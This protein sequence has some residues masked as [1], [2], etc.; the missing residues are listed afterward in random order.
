[1]Q[2]KKLTAYDKAIAE[3]IKTLLEKEK[4]YH[5]LEFNRTTLA[6]MLHL[7]E[8]H[9]SRIINLGFGQTFTELVNQHR[10]EEA[11]TILQETDFPMTSISF[12]VGFKS[13]TSFNRVFKE[14]TGMSP[15]EFRAASTDSSDE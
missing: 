5:Q 12:D 9:V 4:V 2:Q 1:M 6:D 13:I 14:Y 7:T 15:S 10:V 3:D 11:K 8:Q